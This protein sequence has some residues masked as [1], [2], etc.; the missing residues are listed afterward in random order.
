MSLLN[1][2]TGCI[3]VAVPL[4][5]P[6]ISIPSV[7]PPTPC[8]R[9][10]GAIRTSTS[11]SRCGAIIPVTRRHPIAGTD[12]KATCRRVSCRAA[13]DFLRPSRVDPVGW[14]KPYRPAC[15]SGNG[16]DRRLSS[17]RKWSEPLRNFRRVRP[18][19]DLAWR[20]GRPTLALR[21]GPCLPHGRGSK[22]Q[23][24]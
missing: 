11:A 20:V 14:Y 6:R 23:P 7:S 10:L 2:R 1:R 4:R 8:G 12:G 9:I 22:S 15:T 19:G 16:G 5:A 3:N 18:L 24:R 13:R 21:A 17:G